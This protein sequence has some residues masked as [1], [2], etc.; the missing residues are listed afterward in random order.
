MCVCVW[1]GGKIEEKFLIWKMLENLF[2]LS[3]FEK[4]KKIFMLS[5]DGTVLLKTQKIE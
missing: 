4:V 1:G 2:L 5:E 3:F